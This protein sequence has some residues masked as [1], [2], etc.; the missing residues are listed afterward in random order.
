MIGKVENTFV[1][2]IILFLLSMWLKKTI[3]IYIYIL[4]L[5]LLL[6]F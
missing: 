4:L 5:L 3:H 2:N 6:L 1:L